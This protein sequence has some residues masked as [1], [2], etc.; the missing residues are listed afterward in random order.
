MLTLPSLL[1]P[2]LLSPSDTPA[3]R[4]SSNSSSRQGRV[5]DF[6]ICVALHAQNFKLFGV[7][8]RIRCGARELKLES[9]S[10]GRTSHPSDAPGSS[11]LTLAHFLFC[12]SSLATLSYLDRSLVRLLYLTKTCSHLQI[13]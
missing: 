5:E 11:S 12:L 1:I 13:F 6:Q 10:Q 2:L 7:A 8:L 9:Y 3:T 4:A